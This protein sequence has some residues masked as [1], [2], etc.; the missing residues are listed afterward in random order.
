MLTI[1]SDV[2]IVRRC[3]KQLI[4]K[5]TTDVLFARAL[6]VVSM[7]SCLC[8]QPRLDTVL[9]SLIENLN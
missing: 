3:V 6:V 4:K 1:T 9:V 7:K 8:S 5:I 2:F